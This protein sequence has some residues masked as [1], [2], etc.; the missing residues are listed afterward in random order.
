MAFFNNNSNAEGQLLDTNEPSVELPGLGEE[1]KASEKEKEWRSRKIRQHFDDLISNSTFHGLHF[2]FDKKH[3]IRRICWSILILTAFGLLVQKLYESTQHFFSYPFSTTTTIKYKDSMLFPAVSICNL[4]DF[5]LSMMKNTTLHKMITQGGDFSKLDG[6]EYKKT[7]RRANHKIED[8]LYKCKIKNEKCTAKNFTH[9]YHNQ[10]DKCFTFNSG[11]K[12]YRLINVNNT[13]LKQALELTIHIEHHDYYLDTAESGLHLILHGQD[14]TPVK[15]QGVMVSPGFKTFVQVKKRKLKNLPAPYKTNCG[16]LRLKYFPTYSMH[17][18]WLEKLTD[19]VVGKC[20]CKDWFMPGKHKVCTLQESMHCMWGHWAA[21][22]N[23]K[24][25]TCP[26]PCVIDTYLPTLSFAHYPSNKFA[27]KLANETNITGTTTE[28]RRYIRD[29]YLQV[30][31]YY[32]EL[33]YEL[34]EQLPSYD[35]M[36]L[37][38]DIGGQLGLF[39]GSS[40][41]T[42]VEFFDCLIMVIYTR[43]FEIFRTRPQGV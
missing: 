41:L 29:N 8:M 14:E 31:I 2:C 22:D 5:R 33:S 21:F 12:G 6:D 28:K 17:L 34:M 26:L 7:I 43:F 37:L 11:H 39:L 13:G 20:G 24:M 27:D 16:K 9:F 4:N 19:H 15:M 23:N 35:L 38:G 3:S 10:G 18:C 32:S 42:Y 36:V 30:V 25:Y 40:V 1:T